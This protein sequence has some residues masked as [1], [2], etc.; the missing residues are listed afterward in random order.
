[1]P[2]SQIRSGSL[3]YVSSEIER[4]VDE[5]DIGEEHLNWSHRVFK[6]TIESDYEEPSFDAVIPAVVYLADRVVGPELTLRDIADVARR[7]LEYIQTVSKSINDEVGLPIKLQTAE[8]L[9]INRLD[10]F[11]LEEYEEEFKKVLGAVDEN[12]KGS[13]SPASVAAAV[14]YVATKIY[15]FDLSQAE[16]AEEFGVTDVTIRNRYPEVLERSTISPPQGERQ[17]SDFK[18]ALDVLGTDLGVP[19]EILNRAEA[20]V[21]LVSPD[22]GDSVS[23]AGIVLAAI[24]ET[25][26]H[27]DGPTRLTRTTKLADYAAVSELTIDKHREMFS[28]T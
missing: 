28:E 8:N 17:F 12:Y 20:R 22:L 26:A 6:Q 4:I 9:L 5:L 18:E 14:V 25:A 1:M 10:K 16:I 13:K 27:D 11:E 7:D 21:T 2:G 15:N 23:E 3:R 24:A 19:E